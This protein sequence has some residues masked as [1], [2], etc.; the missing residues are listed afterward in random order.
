MMLPA[1]SLQ[2]VK[3]VPE[4]QVAPLVHGVPPAAPLL[5]PL[6]LLVEELP[7]D[8]IVLDELLPL[9]ELLLPDELLLLDELLPL[10]E[11]ALQAPAEQESPA[12]QLESIVQLV[13]QPEVAPLQT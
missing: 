6:E 2:L 4:A 1:T 5:P 9:D 11:L 8:E 3:Q 13:G 12:M 7:L 10:D